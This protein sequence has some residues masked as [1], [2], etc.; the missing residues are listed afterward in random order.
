MDEYYQAT[1]VLK[2][3]LVE[4][5]LDPRL[6]M[7]YF[8]KH[9]KKSWLKDYRKKLDD[10]MEEVTTT[11][12]RPSANDDTWEA[13]SEVEVMEDD[14]MEDTQTTSGSFGVWYDERPS[15]N[16][17]EDE[18]TRYLKSPLVRNGNR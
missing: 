16:I 6:K 2:V 3:Y 12:G 7:K 17:E 13:D 8:K 9:W 18:W 14:E 10:L 4:S 11:M 1:D 15:V 5:V